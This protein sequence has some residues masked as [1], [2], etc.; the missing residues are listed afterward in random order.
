[1]IFKN[2]FVKLAVNRS[3]QNFAS[4]IQHIIRPTTHACVIYW[5]VNIRLHCEEKI[6]LKRI[7]SAKYIN[8]TLMPV[9][10]NSTR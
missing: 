5:H 9:A 8:L 7:V 6:I 4:S 10:F 3:H 1:M 2:V